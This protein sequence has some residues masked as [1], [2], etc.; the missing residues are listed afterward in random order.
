MSAPDAASRWYTHGWNRTISWRLIDAIIPRVPR[1]LRPPLHLITTLLFFCLMPRERRAARRNLERVTGRRGLAATWLAFRLFYNFS[2]YMVASL[3]LRPFRR[4]AMERRVSGAEEARRIIDAALAAGRGLVVVTL[5]LGQWEVGL[6]FLAGDGRPVNVVVRPDERAGG[7][8]YEAE[9]RADPNIRIL[10]AGDSPWNSLDLLLAL[11]RGEM[12]AVQGDRAFG[13][14]PRRVGL[15]GAP[16]DLPVG[17]LLLAQAAGAPLVLICLPFRGHGRYR[18]HIDGPLRVGPGEAA[19]D[20]ALADY[21]RRVQ[22][23]IAAYPT[24]WFNFYPVW[25]ERAAL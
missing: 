13:G 8:R 23:A 14:A 12:V 25:E 20:A 5:H 16:V 22:A 4:D 15:F 10:A 18:V 19:I 11:R 21:R 17:P 7:S 6:R 3:D 24:Q 1:L 2:K 9:A